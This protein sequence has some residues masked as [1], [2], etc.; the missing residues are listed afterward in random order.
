MAW[1]VLGMSLT[2]MAGATGPAAADDDPPR[3]NKEIVACSRQP[4]PELPAEIKADLAKLGLDWKPIKSNSDFP[5]Y[6]P[7][8]IHENN[9]CEQQGALTEKQCLDGGATGIQYT[10]RLVLEGWGRCVGGDYDG[11]RTELPSGT[12]ATTG[13]AG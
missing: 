12:S 9:P 8:L 1:A 6:A 11:Q 13:W 10:G 5:P 3:T 4:L 2:A 7:S